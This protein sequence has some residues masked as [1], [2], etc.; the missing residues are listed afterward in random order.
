MKRILMPK[1]KNKEKT[2]FGIGIT[3]LL[4]LPFSPFRVFFLARAREQGR[5]Q[6]A[7]TS[8]RNSKKDEALRPWWSSCNVERLEMKR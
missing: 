2:F 6:R 3:F 8:D 7:F 5:G 1:K 4:F